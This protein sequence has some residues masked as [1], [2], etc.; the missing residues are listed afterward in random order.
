MCYGT[1]I[2]HGFADVLVTSQRTIIPLLSNQSMIGLQSTLVK[3]RSKTIS[4]GFPTS[5]AWTNILKQVTKC[6]KLYGVRKKV[7]GLSLSKIWSLNKVSWNVV[8]SSSR[9]RAILIVGDG[10]ILRVLISSRARCFT[11][12][13]GIIQLI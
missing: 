12:L 3:Q 10:Q 13:N 4:M 1:N 2:A 7:N 9:H 6:P 8:M 5:T 11:Q